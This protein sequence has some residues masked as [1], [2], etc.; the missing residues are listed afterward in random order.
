MYEYVHRQTRVDVQRPFFT[1]SKSSALKLE[2]GKAINSLS[3]WD[4]LQYNKSQVTSRF[5]RLLKK[6]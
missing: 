2:I 6:N 5:V 3:F 1:D 4:H